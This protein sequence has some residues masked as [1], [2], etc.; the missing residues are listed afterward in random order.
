ML[1]GTTA[2]FV[3]TKLESLRRRIY[4]FLEENIAILNVRINS[5]WLWS[6]KWE[7]FFNC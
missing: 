4:S 7:F 2:G 3:I 6:R 5:T 1:S